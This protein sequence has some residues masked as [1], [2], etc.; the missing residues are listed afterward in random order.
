[1]CRSDHAATEKFVH[2]GKKLESFRGK[3]AV[4][5]VR[6]ALFFCACV[7]PVRVH[8]CESAYASLTSCFHAFLRDAVQ[9]VGVGSVM[10]CVYPLVCWFFFLGVCSRLLS[11]SAASQTSNAPQRGGRF[12]LTQIALPLSWV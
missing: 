5:V 10:L 4:R 8:L 3:A 11:I 2:F 1:M 12:A 7:Y 9:K 6:V